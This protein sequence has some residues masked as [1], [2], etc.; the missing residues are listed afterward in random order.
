MD[1]KIT[2]EGTPAVIQEQARKVEANQSYL[3]FLGLN[4]AYFE[5]ADSYDSKVCDNSLSNSFQTCLY[6]ERVSCQC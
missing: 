3:D 1:S 4:A 2:L 5:W 6:L